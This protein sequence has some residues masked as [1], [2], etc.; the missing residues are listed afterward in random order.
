MIDGEVIQAIAPVIEFL[1]RHE[2]RY[3]IAGSVASSIHGFARSTNDADLVAEMLP[4]HVAD[5]VAT[6]GDDF[7]VAEPAVREAIRR[8]RSFNVIFLETMFKVDVFIRKG[9]QFDEVAIAR[10]LRIPVAGLEQE[11]GMCIA[12]AEDTVLSKLEWYRKGGEISER[13]W[14]DIIGVLKIQKPTLDWDYLRRWAKELNVN[15]L[16][17]L[18]DDAVPDV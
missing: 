9:R 4:E 6:V 7:Y 14:L 11:G 2:I 17:T 3:Y 12:S 18:A 15:D 5:F 8:R 13:Q 1:E 10:T 16:L